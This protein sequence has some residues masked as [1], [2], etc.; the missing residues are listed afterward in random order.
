M[1]GHKCENNLTAVADRHLGLNGTFESNIGAC[2]TSH[3][4]FEM[5]FN[6]HERIKN[7]GTSNH[8]EIMYEDYYLCP[9]IMKLPV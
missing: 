5:H 3:V 9:K 2:P 8:T 7:T 6:F 1:R 4:T